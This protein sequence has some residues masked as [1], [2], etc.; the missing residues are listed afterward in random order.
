MAGN[1]ITCPPVQVFC[2]NIFGN[3]STRT[4]RCTVTVYNLS[5][6]EAVDAAVEL[7]HPPFCVEGDDEGL[8]ELARHD[9]IEDE[10]D[11]R[12]DEGHGVHEVAQWHVAVVHEVVPVHG[13][14]QAED[15]LRTHGKRNG[16]EKG[17]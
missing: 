13:G 17:W 3:T 16:N 15:S 2:P 8:S 5:H 1:R 7:G 12:V 6:L 10:V 14:E 9:A 4:F 11:G